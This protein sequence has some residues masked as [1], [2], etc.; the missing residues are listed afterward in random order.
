MGICWYCHWGWPKA[1]RD[2]YDQ[3]LAKLDGNE[4]LHFGSAHIVWED[5]NFDSAQWCLDNFDKYADDLSEKEKTIVRE[6][7]EQLLLISGRIISAQPENYDDEH[8]ENYP[9]PSDIEW[10]NQEAQEAGK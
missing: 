1:I 6:S 2:I 10:E 5:D 8:P 3:V 9:P 7:L 4:P